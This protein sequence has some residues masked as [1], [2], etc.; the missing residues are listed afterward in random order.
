MNVRIFKHLI[1]NFSVNVESG[2]GQKQSHGCASDNHQNISEE[3]AWG[4]FQKTFVAL[5]R[6]LCKCAFEIL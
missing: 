6:Y 2:V 4:V 3:R 5:C 1:Y